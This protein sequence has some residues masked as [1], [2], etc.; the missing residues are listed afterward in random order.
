[1]TPAGTAITLAITTAI[2]TLFALIQKRSR[3]SGKTGCDE[4]IE[5]PRSPCSTFPNQIAN[6]AGRLLS[7][8]SRC[9]RSARLAGSARSPSISEAGLPGMRRIGTNTETAMINRVS[10]AMRIRRMAKRSTVVPPPLLAD[11]FA[12]I[13]APQARGFA[14]ASAGCRRIAQDARG[15]YALPL[16]LSDDPQ[17]ASDA[18]DLPRTGHSSL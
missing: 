14:Q 16:T 12:T 1:M 4:V 6:C 3:T 13:R 8:P 7:R 15:S 5:F 18:Y 9:C 2:K 11:Q 17:G 10:T